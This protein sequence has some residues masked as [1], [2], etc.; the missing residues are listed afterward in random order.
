M[1]LKEAKKRL[2]KAREDYCKVLQEV[3]CEVQREYV[4]PYLEKTGKQMLVGNG[5]FFIKGSL[6]DEKDLPKRVYNALYL[7]T[8]RI[9]DDPLGCFMLDYHPQK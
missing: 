9:C 8:P 4:N 7:E 3:A 5:D 2:E 1:K 6:N